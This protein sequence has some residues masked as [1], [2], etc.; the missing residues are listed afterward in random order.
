MTYYILEIRTAGN[1]MDDIE[2]EVYTDLEEAKKDFTEAVN[3][4]INETAYD[5][6][7]TTK[8]RLAYIDELQKDI[9]DSVED[10]SDPD[11]EWQVA[12]FIAQMR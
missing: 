1:A 6:E 11:G 10:V 2:R 3:K 9:L 5:N 8:D 7:M 4:K 12:L